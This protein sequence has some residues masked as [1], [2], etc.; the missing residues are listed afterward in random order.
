MNNNQKVIQYHRFF[1][2]NFTR[3]RDMDLRDLEKKLDYPRDEIISNFI[4]YV[5][6][7]K[8]LASQNLKVSNLKE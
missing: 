6:L 8:L 5:S 4:L 1:D 7:S 2:E 3:V